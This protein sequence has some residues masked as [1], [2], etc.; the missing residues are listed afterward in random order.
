M[1]MHGNDPGGKRRFQWSIRWIVT[2][3]SVALVCATT[4]SVWAISEKNTREAL[5]SEL[6]NRLMLEARNLA[7]SS[8]GPLLGDYPELTL[9]PLDKEM[10][11]GTL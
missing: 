4:L 1:T 11:A 6:D 5:S 8:S 10:L 3:A 7:L 9:H 2:G